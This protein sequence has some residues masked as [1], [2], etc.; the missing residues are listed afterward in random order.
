[1]SQAKPAAIAAAQCGRALPFRSGFLI[2]EAT[3]PLV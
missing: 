2:L 3:P 1:M